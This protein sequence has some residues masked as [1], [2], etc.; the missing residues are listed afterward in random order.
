MRINLSAAV[1]LVIMILVPPGAARAL[2]A[3]VDDA[4]VL[5]KKSLPSVIY[6]IC[7]GQQNDPTPKIGTGFLIKSEDGKVIVITNSH[8]IEGATAIDAMFNDGTTR[9][10]QFIDRNAD[11]DLAALSFAD[12]G[13]EELPVLKTPDQPETLPE[14]G[15]KVIMIGHPST[16]KW[17][18][19]QGAVSKIT[20]LQELIDAGIRFLSGQ[21]IPEQQFI[22]L[23]ITSIQGFSGA[24]VIDLSG[25]V[26][27]VQSEGAVAGMS[28]INFSIPIANVKKLELS[29]PST[30]L[31]GANSTGMASDLSAT[32][33]TQQVLVLPQKED[34]PVVPS[35]L[36]QSKTWGRVPRDGNFI[37]T[38]M[39]GDRGKFAEFILPR[40]LDDI[41]ARWEVVHVTNPFFGFSFLVPEAFAFREEI[42]VDNLSSQVVLTNLDQNLQPPLNSLTIT[43]R[44]IQPPS[45]ENLAREFN[46]LIY[47]FKHDVIRINPQVLGAPDDDPTRELVVLS[48]F[49]SDF[50]PRIHDT[51]NI[52]RFTQIYS[53]QADTEQ[54]RYLFFAIRDDTF[55]VADFR[56]NNKNLLKENTDAVGWE[57][58]Y[59]ERAFIAASI[60]FYE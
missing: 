25:R 14:V 3:Q 19:H 44:K 13:G 9:V 17:T 34:G 40:H 31:G 53:R 46:D 56:F 51:R 47:S 32:R 6:L 42:N 33:L 55:L 39:V 22:Q 10:C 26:V 29:K 21:P 36:M 59:I 7:R 38:N 16:L 60:S 52:A 15:T 57:A 12:Q 48:N 24:P 8:V 54:S 1:G 58:N 4:V 2:A 50:Q 35:A 45:R 28:G 30:N 18:M 27:A 23:D 41:V 5:R 49:F 11:L 43:A 20:T 37:F